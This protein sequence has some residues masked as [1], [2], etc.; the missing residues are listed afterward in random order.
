[1]VTADGFD[2]E[3][4]FSSLTRLD[5]TDTKSEP[6]L[7]SLGIIRSVDLICHLWQQYV[8][9]ALLPLASSSVTTRR[10]MAVFNNQTV[11]RIE[12]NANNLLQKVTDCMCCLIPF[13]V[14]PVMFISYL[15]HSHCELARFAINETKTERFQAAQWWS[16]FCTGKYRALRCVLRFPRKSPRFR[17]PESERQ[18]PGSVPDRN[19]CCFSQVW[20][21]SNEIDWIVSS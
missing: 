16:V 18:E 12:T 4:F 17:N 11:T 13:L 7:Q 20:A 1:M 5:V 2:L 3:F 6:N 21:S 14:R 10:E 8:N 15:F 19:W 9:T